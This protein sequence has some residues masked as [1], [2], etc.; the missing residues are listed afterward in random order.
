[1]ATVRDRLWIWG[2][3]ANSFA[4][5]KQPPSRITP[6]E[7][8]HYMGIPNCIMVVFADKPEPP[9]DQHALAMST[10][11]RVVWSV[12]GDAGSKRNNQQSD[13]Q[14]V[15]DIAAKYPNIK[16][17]ILDDFFRHG[18]PYGTPRYTVE[19]FAALR[20]GL[21]G[22]GLDLW[23]VLYQAELDNPIQPY[24]DLCDVITYWTPV[25]SGFANLERDFARCEELTSDKRHVLGVYMGK[26]AAYIPNLEYQC[27]LGLRWLQEGRIEG[28]CVLGTPACDMGYP[29]VEWVREWVGRVGAQPV[30]ALPG[31]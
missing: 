4:H 24:L 16:G 27:D 8:C 6:A 29:T 2:H 3:E 23:V 19:Q 28:V 15:L 22:G 7:A 31:E 25:K 11:D 13:L 14:P 26:E 5:F 21:H 9:F 17:G 12:V 1:M 20:Q 18:Q 10:L 30:P